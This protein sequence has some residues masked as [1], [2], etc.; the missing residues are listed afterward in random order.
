MAKNFEVLAAAYFIG[1]LLAAFASLKLNSSAVAAILL[2]AAIL[3]LVLIYCKRQSYLLLVFCSALLLITGVWRWNQAMVIPADDVSKFSGRQVELIAKISNIPSMVLAEN[4]SYSVNCAAT[5]LEIVCDGE[6]KPVSGGVSVYLTAATPAAIPGY[7]EVLRFHAKLSAPAAYKNPGQSSYADYLRQQ[8]ITAMARAEHFEVQSSGGWLARLGR[9]QQ[10]AKLAAIENMPPDIAAVYNG[11]LFGGS[12]SVPKQIQ[13]E[14]RQTGIVHILSVSGTHISLVAATVFWLFSFAGVPRCYSALVAIATA[15]LYVFFAGFVAAAVRAALMASFALFAIVI[16]NESNIKRALWLAALVILFYNPLN[17]TN[18]G[19]LLSLSATFGIAYFY[20]GVYSI[21]ARFLPPKLAQVLAFTIVAQA[22]LLP[23]AALF[24]NGISIVSLAAN[25]L[26]TPLIDIVLIVG[27]FSALV[28]FLIVKKLSLLLALWG[29]KAAVWIN[30]GL[31]KL[32]GGRIYLPVLTWWQALSYYALLLTGT[33]RRQAVELFGRKIDKALLVIGGAAVWIVILLIWILI[34]TKLQIHFIDVGE[35]DATLVI[36]PHHHAVLLDCGG[37]YKKDS[38][39]FDVG[40]RVVVPYLLHFG[41]R[42]LDAVIISHDHVDHA[43]GLPAVNR[44]IIVN[45]VIKNGTA[46]EFTVDGVDFA[47]SEVTSGESSNPNEHMLVTRVS[48]GGLTA[49]ITG[50]LGMSG[51]H[52]LI[53]QQTRIDAAILK[54]GHH[55]SKTSTSTEFLQ[56]VRPGYAVIS[57]GRDNHY[58]HPAA[59]VIQAIEQAG[60]KTYRTDSN[61]AIIFEANNNAWRATPFNN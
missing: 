38:E 39:S 7:G 36:T 31:A 21:L 32:P 8:G 40:E 10:L 18:V 60:A 54:I 2:V 41:I 45:R 17:L 29:L 57:V 58:G 42:R 46:T 35:G 6:E 20:G 27:L 15:W 3:S 28:P 13:S 53:K 4:G 14:F 5:A 50:D 24:F 61:G 30:A 1:L 23:F 26:V 25:I 11:I 33:M 52:E 48:S 43:G 37:N 12:A 49:L 47:F 44:A 56:A 19:F 59:S 34:P 22:G 55:G 51:E 16:S 9:W